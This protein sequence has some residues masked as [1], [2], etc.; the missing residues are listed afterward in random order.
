MHELSI[1]QA[2]VEQL[3]GIA[4]EN[5]ALRVLS[6]KLDVGLLSGVDH[7]ALHMAFPFASEGTVAEGAGLDITDIDPKAMCGECGKE[8]IPEFP[9]MVC[10]HCGSQDLT[11]LAGRELVIKSAELDTDDKDK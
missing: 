3:E 9:F 2:L 11:V 4:A 5:N 1:A 10:G 6:V 8:S 7:E